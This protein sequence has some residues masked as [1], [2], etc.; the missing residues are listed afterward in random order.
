[1]IAPNPYGSGSRSCGW[2]GV[3]L[4]DEREAGDDPAAVFAVVALRVDAHG[5]IMP[6]GECRNVVPTGYDVRSNYLTAA[7]DARTVEGLV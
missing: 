3:V 1:M 5:R 4:G 2:K 6:T 7:F